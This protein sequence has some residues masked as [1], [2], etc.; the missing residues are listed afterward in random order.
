MGMFDTVYCNYP[1][2]VSKKVI[3]TGFDYQGHDYQTKDLDNFL[4]VYTITEEGDL[5]EKVVEREWIDDDSAFLK[6]Y[7]KEISSHDEK[8]DFHGIINF[9]TYHTINKMVEGE[10]KETTITLDYEAKFTDGK[11]QS[12]TLLDEEV[13]DTTDQMKEQNLFFER[14]ESQSKKWYNKYIFN[15]KI[16]SKFKKNFLFTPIYKLHNLTGKLHMW[17]VRT[18]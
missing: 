12:I 5:I 3:D 14:L 2:P 18:F 15:T 11:L 6:G 7:M 1:L 13:S 10:K 16:Y 8:I 9:Y 4:N 17:V